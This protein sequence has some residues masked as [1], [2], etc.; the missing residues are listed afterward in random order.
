MVSIDTLREVRSRIV[1]R[2][3]SVPIYIK[4]LGIGFLV[5]LVF[6]ATVFH[7]IKQ[8]VFRTHCQVHAEMAS[9]FASTLAARIAPMLAAGNR[10]ALDAALHDMAGSFVE[11]RYIVVQDAAGQILSHGFTFPR[12]A[13]T[14]LVASPRNLCGSCHPAMEAHEIAADMWE[15]LPQLLTPASNV[16]A[17]T[18]NAGLILEATVPVPQGDGASVRVGVGGSTINRVVSSLTVSLLLILVLCS[19]IGLSFALVLAYVIVR[20][21]H[22]L[23]Q[24]TQ[25]IGEGD[26]TARATVMSEDEVGIL[27]TSFN[28]MA[29]ALEEYRRAVRE[30]E[31]M[32]LSLI[33]RIVQAQEDE[34]KAIARELHDQLGQSLS[35]AL[36]TIESSCQN[37]CNASAHCGGVKAEIRALIDQVRRIAWDTRPSIIDDYGL[38]H[39]LSR[40]VEEMRRRVSFDIAYQYAGPEDAPR[41][42][43]TIEVSLYRIAQEAVTNI[44]RHA[45]A[46]EV[47]LILMRKADEVSLIV[48]D[49]GCGF[50]PSAVEHAPRPPLGLIG[51]R[52]RVALV[53]GEFA[54]YS[55]PGEG[56][57]V[58]VRIAIK[59]EAHADSR[60]SG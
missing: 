56:T 46:T 30:Q 17:F 21:L 34:R 23:V 36:L 47:S 24:L 57:T 58:R 41:L 55:H 15:V 19:V 12:E 37:C 60:A 38:N 16:R 32:R 51:M 3:M 25:R 43:A 45:N 59:E 18:R 14:D 7:Q 22:D 4:I 8:G 11:I 31:S 10:P 6:G 54:I 20:P 28:Q 35:H 9:S 40:Y 44:L 53:G 13:P 49:N 27:A 39:A 26:F 29:E 48:E 50:D 2:A 5:S 1:W 52:E 42:P 33:G